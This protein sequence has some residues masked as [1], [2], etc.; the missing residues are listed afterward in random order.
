M[1]VAPDETH[2]PG[3]LAMTASDLS[4]LIQAGE[5]ESV[6]LK[7]STGATR[8]IVETVCAFANARGGTILIG[9]TNTGNICGVTIGQDTLEAL[10]NSIQQQ[11]D[12]KV[13]PVLTTAT[14]NGKTMVV[15]RIE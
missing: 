14:V 5:S 8:E 4:A 15:L 6:E 11:T 10:S 2:D 3:R 1:T 13:F 9:V 12:P 7:Q